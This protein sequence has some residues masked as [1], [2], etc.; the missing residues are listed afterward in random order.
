MRRAL[1]LV[2]PVVGPMAVRHVA[3]VTR[4]QDPALRRIYA[5]MADD[6]VPAAPPFVVHAAQPEVLGGL[7][8][9]AREAWLA[10]PAARGPREAVA[11]GLSDANRC[12]FC[13][14]VHHSA[15]RAC[16]GAHED[17]LAWGRASALAATA[18][19][20]TR[21]FSAAEAP[22]FLGTALLFHYVNR[23]A[24]VLLKDSPFPALVGRLGRPAQ[25]VG[26]L[27]L[28]AAFAGRR[29]EPGR[30]ADLAADGPLPTDLA[31]AAPNEHVA[32][33]V[34]AFVAAVERASAGI[35][36]PVRALVADR[37]RDWTGGAP[38]LS[39][40]WATDAAVELP[41]EARAAGELALTVALAPF[42]VDDAQVAAFR[43]H[44]ASDADL[45]GLLAFAALAA[46]R[47]V[48][49]WC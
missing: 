44:G 25:K 18:G 38:A 5:A 7:W 10:G 28:G 20:A 48:L 29:V 15:L 2:M 23:I 41:A 47:R 27:T 1:S 42:Q 40:S 34:G 31:W 49:S 13:I 19:A 39:R 16:G 33:A 9:L 6:L 11:A 32:A 3:K 36:A 37:V 30:Y 4:P 17:V 26:D 14:E 22:Q 46:S 43:A 21:P 45:V 24:E 12:P 35:P 8:R